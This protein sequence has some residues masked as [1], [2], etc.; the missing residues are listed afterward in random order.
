DGTREVSWWASN[1]G[2]RVYEGPGEGHRSVPESRRGRDPTRVTMR[3]LSVSGLAPATLAVG[4]SSCRSNLT[5]SHLREVWCQPWS[6]SEGGRSTGNWKCSTRT[7]PTSR[8]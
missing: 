2:E 5:R 4:S 1:A 6:H 8:S 3:L 7:G